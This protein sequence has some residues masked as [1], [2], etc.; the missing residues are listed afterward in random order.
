VG[1]A[2]AFVNGRFVPESELR[3]SPVDAGFIYGAIATDLVRTFRGRLFRLGDH[4]RRLRDSC[5]RAEIPLEVSDAELTAAAERLAAENRKSDDELALVMFATPG[6]IGRYAGREA[7]GPATIGMHTMPISAARYR[8]LFTAGARLVVP[9]IRAQRSI[10]PRAKV[11]SRLHWWLA[12][13][14]A[15]RRDPGSWALLVDERGCATETAAANLLAVIGGAVISPPRTDVLNGI[16]LKV[17]EELCCSLG[18]PFVERP[19]PLTEL[20]NAEDVMLTGTMFCLAGVCRV[21][22]TE[23]SWPGPVTLRLQSAWMNAVGHDFVRGFT[24]LRGTDP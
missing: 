14:E 9:S 3:I 7:D 22:D 24:E 6:P 15:H 21:D 5:R 2:I 20:Y 13:R 23:L 17:T 8:H 19:L 1:G 16:S 12:E 18:I 4:V 11:R 10:D